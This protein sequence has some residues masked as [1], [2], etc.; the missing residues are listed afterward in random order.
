M[1][2]G[3]GGRALNQDLRPRGDPRTRTRSP[4]PG[5]SRGEIRASHQHLKVGRSDR[6]SPL[7]VEG[8]ERTSSR[9]VIM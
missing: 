2:E 1:V 8:K 5:G 7:I 4:D 6:S 3:V 9:G